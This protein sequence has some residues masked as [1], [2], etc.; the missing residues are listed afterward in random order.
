[1]IQTIT[2]VILV[3]LVLYLRLRVRDLENHIAYRY[4]SDPDL[5]QTYAHSYDMACERIAA[6]AL[7]YNRILNKMPLQ[8]AVERARKA[9]KL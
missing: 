5:V 4:Q 1:M 3:L 8:Q 9:G 7:T 2:L 6:R